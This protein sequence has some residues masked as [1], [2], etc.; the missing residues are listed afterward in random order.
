MAP[1]MT[2]TTTEA[3]TQTLNTKQAKTHKTHLLMIL[4]GWGY[5][6]E[7]DANAIA[8]ANTP[9]WDA[10]WANNPHA[11]ISGSG[12][13]VGLPAGQMGNSEVGHMN[14]GAGRVVYQDLTRIDKAISDGSF[15]NN[16]AICK[17][18]K[19]CA[20][21]KQKFHI[22]GLL[23]NGGVHSHENHIDAAI[24]LAIEQG[25]QEIYLHAFLDGRDTA[26]R[27]AQQSLKRFDQKLK[28]KNCGFIVS[29]IGRYYAMDRDQRWDRVELAYNL[30]TQGKAEFICEN[31]SQ[32]LELAYERDENDEFVQASS[33]RPN[34]ETIVIDDNDSVLF[35]NFRADRA[36]QISRALVNDNFDGFKRAERINKHNFLC[37]THYADDIEAACAFL[38][39]SISNDIGEYL[40]SLG[41]TQLRI[42]ETEKYAHVTFFFS[43][44]QESLYPGEERELIP[45]PNVATYD[46]Q[47]EMSAFEL[48]DKLCAAIETQRYDLI[49]CN[50]ANGDMVGHTGKL[51]AAIL[52]AE[53]LDKCIARVKDSLEKTNSE[54]L[55][56]ADHGNLEC[57]VDENSKQALTSHTCEPVPLVY[58]GRN[59]KLKDGGL[60]SDVAPTL[61]KMMNIQAPQEMTGKNLIE[62]I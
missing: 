52:A 40:S 45:S 13:D 10:L 31:A 59:A 6:E 24:D 8:L 37:L 21:N 51:D 29:V 19:S 34:G 54:C 25:C 12:E 35:M 39:Q 7:R 22:M 28:E 3:T 27:S 58:I 20:D 46:L 26:P 1:K 30:L 2:E 62:F 23:S 60:L 4:D 14:L 41:K 57:M 48:T 49:I 5:R 56:T 36:R 17:L 18:A 53:T 61:L 15:L 33:I 32:A 9:N 38:P 55:I 16:E 50:Y 42:A 43:G 47:P 44:G 11:L